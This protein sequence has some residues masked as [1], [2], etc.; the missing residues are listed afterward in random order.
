MIWARKTPAPALSDFPNGKVSPRSERP[1]SGVPS[2]GSPRH[3]ADRVISPTVPFR[4]VPL[5]RDGNELHLRCTREPAPADHRHALSLDSPQ[6]GSSVL[7]RDL[8]NLSPTAE[9]VLDLQDTRAV[10]Y[11]GGKTN[12]PF[13]LNHNP[14]VT[15]Y[16]GAAFKVQ[17]DQAE[18]FM[19]FNLP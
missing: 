17:L 2:M 11:Q 9:Y 7:S 8:L 1:Q 16:A 19:R 12:V 5:T 15:T 13:A 6:G 14:Q 3:R 18:W 10:K 4:V